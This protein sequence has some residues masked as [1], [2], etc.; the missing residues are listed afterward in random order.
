MNLYFLIKNISE[1]GFF[2]LTYVLIVVF[3][4]IHIGAR[5]SL[6]SAEPIYNLDGKLTVSKTGQILL[7]NIPIKLQQLGIPKE[8]QECINEKT[9]DIFVCTLLMEKLA[10]AYLK[11]LIVTCEVVAKN[12]KNVSVANCFS[13]EGNVVSSLIIQGIY[14]AERG[15][16]GGIYLGEEYWARITG[17]GIWPFYETHPDTYLNQDEKL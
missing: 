8:N 6:L 2:Y 13:K 14:F 4:F 1:G 9:S 17:A 10:T 7:N 3:L 12:E 11:N 5:M 16:H 15:F